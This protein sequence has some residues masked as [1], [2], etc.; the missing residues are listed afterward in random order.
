MS[1][2]AVRPLPGLAACAAFLISDLVLLTVAWMIYD[3]A[4]RPM[5]LYELAAV[6][7]CTAVGAGLGVWPFVL[8]YRAVLAREERA[9]LADAASRIQRLDE[10]LDRIELAAGQWQTANE[11]AGRAIEAAREIGDRITAETQGFKAFLEQAQH[12]ERQHLQLEVSKLRRAEGDWLQTVVHIL[13]H[14]HALRAAALRSGQRRLIEQLTAFQNACRDATRRVGLVAQEARP[15]APFDPAAH[16]PLNPEAPVP[17]HSV[18]T[19]VIAPGYTYQ[20]QLLR[21]VVV[22]VAPA[23]QVAA[24]LSAQELDFSSPGPM[25]R[26]ES[27][28]PESRETAPETSPRTEPAPP[29]DS[30]APADDSRTSAS[31]SPS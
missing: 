14:V 23:D 25:L 13:D 21:R 3:Q 27:G 30:P 20:G 4:H 22:G 10:V 9:D 29:A 5:Q 31:V 7:G 2:P 6:A 16:Q 24:P 8:R 12:I 11:H 15:G 1:E 17:E 18:V 28:S 19:E 26:G